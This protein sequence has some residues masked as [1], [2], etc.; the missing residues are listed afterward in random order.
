MIRF[1][2]VLAPIVILLFWGGTYLLACAEFLANP[3]VPLKMAY[4]TPGGE[5]E[6]TA[7]SYV[8]NTKSGD[9]TVVQP[10]VVGPDKSVLFYADRVEA[11]GLPLLISDARKAVVKV[12]NA[13]ATLQRGSDGKMDL[14][15][16]LPEQEGPS[17]DFPFAV[18]IDR[19]KLKYVDLTGT[20]KWTQNLALANIQVD[21]VGDR[22]MASGSG[23]L[24]KVGDLSLSVQNQPNTGLWLRGKTDRLELVDLFRA[25]RKT[26]EGRQTP[27]LS[28]IDANSLVVRGPFELFLPSKS[29][30]RLQ[31]DLSAEAEGFRY[32]KDIQAQRLEFNGLVSADGARGRLDASDNGLV[33]D[34]TGFV[35]WKDAFGLDGVLNATAPRTQSL[36]KLLRDQVP[37]NLAVAGPIRYAGKLSYQEKPGW[38]LSGNAQAGSI[39]AY[40]EIVLSPSIDVNYSGSKLALKATNGV[41]RGSSVEGSLSLDSQTQRLSG[42][43][44]LPNLNL[45]N[46]ARRFHIDGLQGTGNLNLLLTGS[47]EKPVA[48]IR[49]QSNG[50]YLWNTDLPAATGRMVLA[51]TLKDNRLRFEQAYIVTSA[52]SVSASGTYNLGTEQLNLVAVGSGIDLD[53]MNTDLEGIGRFKANIGGSLAKPR[54]SGSA[55][56]FGLTVQEQPIPVITTSFTGD[57]QSVVAQNL[58]VVKGA[59]QANGQVSVRFKDMALNGEFQAL[60]L[61]LSDFLGEQYLATIDLSD[62][63]L[64][65][66]LSNPSFSATAKA[67]EIVL[68]NNKMDSA[69]AIISFKSNLLEVDDFV[70]KIGEGG[71]EGFVSY[72][73]SKGNGQANFTAEKIALQNFVPPNLGASLIAELSGEAGIT[74]DGTGLKL[75]SGEGKLANVS[76]NDTELGGGDWKF[77]ANGEEVTGEAFV[78]TLGSSFDLTGFRYDLDSREVGGNA[79]VRNVQVQDLYKIG[80]QYLPSDN[81]QLATLFSQISGTLGLSVDLG[82]TVDNLSLSEGSFLAENLNYNLSETTYR[83]VGT[84]KADFQRTGK[85]W[86]IN[87][88]LW[89]GGPLGLDAK[90]TFTESG[91]IFIE[92]RIEDLDLSYLSLYSDS[93]TNL[94]GKIDS[95]FR[96]SGTTD[97]PLLQASPVSDNKAVTYLVRSHPGSDGQPVVDQGIPTPG[98]GVLTKVPD[99]DKPDQYKQILAN[100][101]NFSFNELSL[102]NWTWQGGGLEGLA[103]LYFEGYSGTLSASLP[104]RYPFDLVPGAPVSAKLLVSNR[105][106]K[107]I[108]QLATVFDT[109]RSEGR[110]FGEVNVSGTKENLLTVGNVQLDA[111]QL[112]VKE[113]GQVFENAKANVGFEPQK[114]VTSLSATSANGGTVNG[115]ASAQIPSL[116][117]ILR[118]FRGGTIAEMFSSPVMGALE[119]NNLVTNLKIGTDGNVASTV[120]GKLDLAGTLKEPSIKGSVRL[121]KSSI[122]MPSEFAAPKDSGSLG[123]NPEFDIRV[124]TNSPATFK[125]ST[126]EIDMAGG[127]TIQGNLNSLDVNALLRV[128]K[129]SLRL[130]TTRVTL[131]PGGTIRPSFAMSNGV[132]DA[133][134]DVELEGKT[135]VVAASRYG[136]GAQRYDVTLDV[137]G[138]LLKDGGLT[139][140]ATS[141][142]G[143]LTQDE[144]LA[145]LGQVSLIEGIASGVQSGNAESQ[146]RDALVGI[147][148][149]YLLDPVTS[150]IASAFTLDYLTLDINA[151]DGASIYFAKTLGRNLT[152]QGSRQVSQ[153][154]QNYPIKYDLRLS[155]QYRFGNRADRRRLNFLIGMDETRPWKIAVEYNFRF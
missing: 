142:P 152:L 117:E 80:K 128:T 155:Y 33:A 148:V 19:A 68:Q 65:G 130:P 135:R 103:S 21:G 41:W 26:P 28:D 96:L 27:E 93:F 53:R 48:F 77:S 115:T 144:I 153:V 55:E 124:Q 109:A 99:P 37:Q 24:E 94:V 64:S 49:A 79:W 32:G 57:L 150:K 83:P 102:S 22:W 1:A 10:K 72:D 112:V 108:S 101:F 111:P 127:G 23:T 88:L 98:I 149:P 4:K 61:Q 3:G 30:A 76:I 139:L 59:S 126:A 62:A 60:G 39:S 35:T 145:L 66:T 40:E 74:F 137:R 131:E 14:L 15:N 97:E 9:V 69:S 52:G 63:R 138:D 38:E 123:I 86:D 81:T 116:D 154:D 2:T 51:A 70:A 18:Q 151:L 82:G 16:Y 91:P 42:A 13:Y 44:K 17:G 134:L 120:S 87:S 110:I 20:E 8:L 132:S 100:P 107:D 121:D 11:L 125:S 114:L 75:G 122:V 5:L 147:A 54:Y 6:I 85:K 12:R 46:L 95:D 141:D 118:M 7:S 146:I 143:D 105:E 29:P 25:F 119:T 58:K 90:G 133:R 78:G 113:G 50:S 67:S 56:L 36:P 34:F 47:V 31:V 89:Q 92:G 71:I 43:L 136:E 129:G 104:F 73:V 84:L 140:N 45:S 106:I